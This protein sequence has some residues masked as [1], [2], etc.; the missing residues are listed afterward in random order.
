MSRKGNRE[1]R[2]GEVGVV[3]VVRCQRVPVGDEEEAVVIF[4]QPHPV[5]QGPVV[6]AEVQRTGGAHAGENAGLGHGRKL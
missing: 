4:L 1:T 3:G 2:I 6:V 5:L